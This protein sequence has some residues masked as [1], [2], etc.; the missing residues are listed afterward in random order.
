MG[1]GEEGWV[2][3]TFPPEVEV[4]SHLTRLTG[5][6]FKFTYAAAAFYFSATLVA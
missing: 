5:R 4:L 1:G 6:Q 3:R 2:G